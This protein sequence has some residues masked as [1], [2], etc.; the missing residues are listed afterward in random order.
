MGVIIS[1]QHV[2]IAVN[3]GLR[4]ASALINMRG[5]LR[6]FNRQTAIT[7]LLRFHFAAFPVRFKFRRFKF[8]LAVGTLL[9]FCK[10]LENVKKM[11]RKTRKYFGMLLSLVSFHVF[12]VNH[13]VTFLAFFHVSQ[14]IG[15]MQRNFRFWKLF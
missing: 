2:F 14:T 9:L 13:L 12:F 8:F 1:Q 7:A 11:L 4:A 15:L 6:F 5:K 10:M 3:A